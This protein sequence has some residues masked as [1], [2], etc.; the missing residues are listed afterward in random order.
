MARKASSRSK[1]ST[2]SES[3]SKTSTK[4]ARKSRKTKAVT[5]PVVE[6]KVETTPEVVEST[7]EPT[8][9]STAVT[10][11]DRSTALFDTLISTLQARITADRALLS[12]L[13]TLRKTVASERRQYSKVLNKYNKRRTGNR[14]NGFQVPTPISAQMAKFVGVPSGS[15]MARTDVTK[16]IHSYIK[17]KNLQNPE[18]GQEIFPDSKLKKLLYSG[19]DSVTYFKLQTYLKP[20]FLRKDKETGEV[21]PFVAPTSS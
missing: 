7:P 17:E 9:N 6:K 14:R 3:T 11:E 12:D 15:E 21:A 10:V 8:A 20:H 13:R 18:N 16:F 4:K 5:E 19:D 2:A 1:K